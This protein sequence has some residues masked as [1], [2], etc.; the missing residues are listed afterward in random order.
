MSDQSTQTTA[1]DAINQGNP[2]TTQIPVNPATNQQL[3]ANQGSNAGGQG[4]DQSGLTGWDGKPIRPEDHSR[5][6]EERNRFKKQ[7]SAIAAENAEMKK[8]LDALQREKMTDQE[9]IQS[10]YK[11]ASERLALLESENSKLRYQNIA[12][13]AGAKDYEFVAWKIQKALEENK[14][15]DPASIIATIKEQHPAVFGTSGSG[16]GATGTTQAQAAPAVQ[17]PQ[18]GAGA[19]VEGSS[20]QR[21]LA[22]I[23]EELKALGEAGRMNRTNLRKRMMLLQERENMTRAAEAV[24]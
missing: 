22:L 14:N 9:K 6:V 11:I 7:S 18:G 4:T 2:G 23:D 10:D 17:T 3:P 24:Q 12:I 5:V 1:Q 19:V 13:G 20:G 16:S 8:Q 21:S 15:A